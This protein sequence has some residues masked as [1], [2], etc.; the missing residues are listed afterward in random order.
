MID[1]PTFS[2]AQAG[3]GA[4]IARLL[5]LI[6]R[7]ETLG[8]TIWSSPLVSAFVEDIIAG[9]EPSLGMKYYTVKV[10]CE[11]EGVICLRDTGGRLFVDNLYFTRRLRK[12]RMSIRST[13]ESIRS[14]LKD[15]ACQECAW[16]GWADNLPVI[17]WHRQLGGV[18]Q[19]R[20]NWFVLRL[21][22][23]PGPP[24]T[25][26]G[27]DEAEAKHA[28]YGFSTVDVV[29]SQGRRS[30]GLLGT[31]AFRVTDDRSIADPEFLAAL[32]FIDPG[33]VVHVYSGSPEL[34]GAGG[35]IA[36]AIRMHAP[37]ERV[38][39]QLEGQLPHREAVR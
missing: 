29:T 30:V 28:R 6:Q 2:P 7:S 10:G 1:D 15:F 13:L 31:H 11:M 25:V 35:A 4:E 9:A 37:I 5:V 36:T 12:M 8:L 14:Y 39:R 33:R 21:P 22:E 23:K 24:G 27:R 17:G 18:E 19:Y 38:L 34:P 32:A 20:K 3:D 26:V 16:D